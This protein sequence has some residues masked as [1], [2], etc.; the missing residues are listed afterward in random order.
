[1]SCGIYKI[2][3]QINKK[4]YIGKSI[5]IERRWS[6]HKADINDLNKQNHLYRAMRL[7]GLENFLFEIIEICPN[8]N[9]ILSEREKFW[10]QYYN[11]YQAGYNETKGGEGL[12]KYDPKEI[13]NLWDNGYSILEITQIVHC[14]KQTVYDNLKN[15]PTYSTQ[16]SNKRADPHRKQK[17]SELA[18]ER[19]SYPV[20]QYDLEGN[21]IAEYANSTT[22]AQ[23]FGYNIDNSICKVINDPNRK[24]AYGYQWSRKKVEA[25]P[26]FQTNGKISVRN[27][28]TGKV[29]SSIRE[30]AKWANID[31]EGIR[32]V[33]NGKRKTA[34]KHPITGEKLYWETLV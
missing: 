28:N 32:R 26:K 34:G 2:T 29:F 11:S 12:F 16:E 23:Q 1:M 9:N 4:V 33:L 14:Q 27:I 5:R 24:L 25:M 3:N 17:I 18:T 10:I 21:F 31:K 22:A 8:D 30:A 15:Y 20:Y 6:Q 13:Y 19:L 7:Y